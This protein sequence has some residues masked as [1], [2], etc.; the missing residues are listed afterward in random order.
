LVGRSERRLVTG[1]TAAD[2]AELRRLLT[3]VYTN[4]SGEPREPPARIW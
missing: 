2:Q 1:L 3:I 4:V